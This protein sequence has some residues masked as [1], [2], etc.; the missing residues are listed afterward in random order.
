MQGIKK[1]TPLKGRKEEVDDSDD[2]ATKLF[3]EVTHNDEE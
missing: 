1:A 2:D 3:C